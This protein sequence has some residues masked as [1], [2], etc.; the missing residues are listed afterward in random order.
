MSSSDPFPVGSLNKIRIAHAQAVCARFEASAEAVALLEEALPPATYLERLVG[1]ELFND[2]VTFLAHAL[3]KRE[4]VWWACLCARG[5]MPRPPG[6]AE[7]AVLEAAEAWVLQPGEENRRATMAKAEAA[8]FDLPSSW[9]GAAAFWSGGSLAP[10]GLPDVPPDDKLTGTA[11]AC[12]V[13][14]AA[15]RVPVSRP[16]DRYRQFLGQGVDIAN[17][18]TGRIKG[19]A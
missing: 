1:A 9:A 14:V 12:A 16:N 10:P 5:S 8:G 4:A 18:G 6:D 11:V 15:H 19:G 7:Q 13:N 3:P 2:A 17:G